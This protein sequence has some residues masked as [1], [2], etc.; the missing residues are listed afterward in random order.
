VVQEA[1]TN[2]VQHGE[3]KN[4]WIDLKRGGTGGVELTIQDDGHGFDIKEGDTANLRAE[5]HRGLSNME[6]RIALVGGALKIIS[7]RGEGTCIRGV[8]P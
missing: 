1:V 3:A 6:E 2:S 4:I 7:Y 5:G 8:L